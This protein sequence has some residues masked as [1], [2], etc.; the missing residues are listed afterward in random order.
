[1]SEEFRTKLVLVLFGIVNLGS[2]SDSDSELLTM[3]IRLN[4]DPFSE[5]CLKALGLEA[6]GFVCLGLRRS[7]KGFVDGPLVVWS[8]DGTHVL[9]GGLLKTGS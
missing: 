4:L 8:L 3:L 7:V 9:F 2:A 6:V 5:G 1:M